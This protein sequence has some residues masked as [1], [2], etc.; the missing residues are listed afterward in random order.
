MAGAT[1]QSS[2]YTT[3]RGDGGRTGWTGWIAFAGVMMV[4]SGTLNALYG[5]IAVVNDDW[6]VWTNRSSLYV[7]ISNWGWVHLVVGLVVLC[8]G[9]GVFSG[10]VLARTVGVAGATISL[11]TNFFFIPA[12]PIWALTVVTIN[13][14]VI[15]ALTAHGAEMRRV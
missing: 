11:I 1:Y 8:S 13:V 5:F 10:N 15:W 3:D 2:E 4:I 12:Y 14:L 7:D 6:V 9:V